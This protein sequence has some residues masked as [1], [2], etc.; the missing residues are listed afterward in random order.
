MK[1]TLFL[2]AALCAWPAAAEAALHAET[3]DYSHGE[4]A[5]EGYLAYDDASPAKR[6]GILLVHDWTGLREEPK[7]R[8][9]ELAKLGYAVFAVD[10]YGKGVRPTDPK[11]AS[12]Q[13][14]IYKNDRALMRERAKAGLDVL[15]KQTVVDASR[16]AAIGYCFGGTTV[17]ELARSGAP[18]RGVVSFHGGLGTP[19]PEDAGNIKGKVLVLHGADDPYSPKEEVEA[20]EDEMRKA[21]VDYQ[22]HLYGGAVH[23][24][25]IHEAGSDNSRG[26]AYNADADRRSWASMRQFFDEIFA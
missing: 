25:T 22:V 7:K 2:L 10:M 20:L 1:R 11:D 3:V 4:T 14:S 23:S 17:L 8:A 24:F 9:E 12:A 19:H 18:L 5:L 21:G 13:A 26:A 16:L 6:P 15:T